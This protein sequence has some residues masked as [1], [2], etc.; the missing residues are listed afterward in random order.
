MISAQDKQAIVDLVD[1]AQQAGAR[2][3]PACELLGVTLRTLQRWRKATVLDD[4]RHGP[5]T[6][7]ANALSAQE[8]VQ[9]LSVANS[10]KYCNQSPNQIVPHL[11]DDGIYIA[12][13]STFYRVLKEEN[14]LA[15]RG[16]STL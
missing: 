1:E 4:K 15:H 6:K 13:E 9:V 12:S 14:L 10:A 16:A 7:P 2:L 8:R 5:L 3:K 11:A